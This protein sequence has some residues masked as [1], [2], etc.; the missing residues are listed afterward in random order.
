MAVDY[1]AYQR[2]NA[3]GKLAFREHFKD[4]DRA[5]YYFGLLMDYRGLVLASYAGMPPDYMPDDR[6]L[7]AMLAQLQAVIGLAYPQKEE[8]SLP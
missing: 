1:E 6:T 2:L 8:D 7:D 4:P 3:E 5:D